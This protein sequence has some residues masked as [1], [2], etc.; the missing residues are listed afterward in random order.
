MSN[1]ALAI[2]RYV[3]DVSACGAI[4]GTSLKRTTSLR[5][6]GQENA[7][8]LLDERTPV[9]ALRARTAEQKLR[10][11][12]EAARIAAG[13]RRDVAGIGAGA[14]RYGADQRLA[15]QQGQAEA[16]RNAALA[17]RSKAS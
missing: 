6:T 10:Q 13:S 16:D 4:S 17:G 15:G 5:R 14:S 2:D 7:A 1:A 11:S 12:T 3:A 8:D 9:G